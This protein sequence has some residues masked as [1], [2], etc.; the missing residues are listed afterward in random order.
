MKKRSRYSDLIA[1]KLSTVLKM[2]IS[3]KISKC[4][5]GSSHIFWTP[6]FSE[7]LFPGAFCLLS[8]LIVCNWKPNIL[9]IM[10]QLAACSCSFFCPLQSSWSTYLPRVLTGLLMGSS[11]PYNW[12]QSST[13]LMTCIWYMQKNMNS[14]HLL[15]SRTYCE[16]TV[17]LVNRMNK[18]KTI[19]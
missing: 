11:T 6:G 18:A 17:F 5:S 9:V 13:D 10:I 1:L 14:R 2:I 3:R 12:S 16:K 7:L 8:F 15:W 4:E 19:L